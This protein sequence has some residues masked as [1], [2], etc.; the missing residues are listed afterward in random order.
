MLLD[1]S[2][3]RSV[4]RAWRTLDLARRFADRGVI[5]IGLAGDESYPLAP[6]N[7]VCIAAEK[8]G[9]HRVHHAGEAAGPDSIREAITLGRT[10]RL[11][12]GI[13][14]LDDPALT[15]EVAALGV[16]LEVCPSSNVALGLAPS[17]AEHPLPR[18]RDAGLLVTL[19][20]DIPVSL[21]VTLSEEYALA[22]HWFGYSDEVLAELASASVRA[23]FAPEPTRARLRAGIAD[24][25]ATA[26]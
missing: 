4:E 13:R 17:W 11:G 8:E 6:F 5:G 9:L 10:E 19:N 3:R 18:L 21:G 7:E 14:I 16:P 26:P 24:W 12:H 2:R 15:A 22:R 20:T 25:L 23:S 1:H